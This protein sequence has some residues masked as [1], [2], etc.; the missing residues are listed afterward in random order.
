MAED[1]IRSRRVECNSA[2]FSSGQYNRRTEGQTAEARTVL[3]FP[4]I[5]LPHGMHEGGCLN[6]RVVRNQIQS[7]HVRCACN[8]PIMWLSNI[9]N[10]GC[11]LNDGKIHRILFI[12][13]VLIHTGFYRFERNPYS[14]FLGQV[15]YFCE[16]YSWHIDVAVPNTTASIPD[17]ISPSP[18]HRDRRHT[19]MLLKGV[20]S[21][22]EV[23]PEIS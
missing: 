7:E 19:A 12:I 1:K 17:H 2:A 10:P 22:F 4:G 23:H 6:N 18:V 11:R 15:E 3:A 20:V 9:S 21:F 8:Q 5:A 13:R 14:L 16:D